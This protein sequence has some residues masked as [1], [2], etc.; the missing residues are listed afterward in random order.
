MNY[1][2]DNKLTDG[3]VGETRYEM[4]WKTYN[5]YRGKTPKKSKYGAKKQTITNSDG[6]V[7]TFDSKKEMQRYIELRYMEQAGL[8]SDLR[9]QVK[10]V[11]IPAQRE[12]DTKG[13]RGG[14]IKGKLLERECAYIADFTYCDSRTGEKVVED[15][16]GVRTAE[17]IIKRKMMLY[18]HGIRIKEV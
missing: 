16:K 1:L 9:R 17:Y 13:K 15:T 12:P 11:L 18:F 2:H 3:I 4:T 6:T 8:I 14:T 5:P 7:L 10:F